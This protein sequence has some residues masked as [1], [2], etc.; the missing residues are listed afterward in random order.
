MFSPLIGHEIDPNKGILVTI[1]AYGS[2]FASIE[3]FIEP[4]DEASK[5][6]LCLFH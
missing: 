2:L 5:M 1:G 3:A 4:G 6:L